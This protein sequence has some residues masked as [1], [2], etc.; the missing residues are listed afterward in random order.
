[1]SRNKTVDWRKCD[2][3]QKRGFAFESDAMKAL[4]RAKTKRTR[5][6]DAQGTRRGVYVE[7]RCYECAYGTWHLT[8]LNKSSYEQYA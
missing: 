5:R 6:A 4:G 2:C 8:S 1:M 7:S 3:G